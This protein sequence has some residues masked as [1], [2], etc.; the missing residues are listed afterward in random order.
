M[1]PSAE[2]F[3]LDSNRRRLFSVFQG[4]EQPPR[5][6][7]LFCHPLGEEKKCAHRAFHETAR[8]LARRGVASL[9]FDFSGCGDSDGV[10][11]DFAIEDWLADIQSAWNELGRRAPHGEH[12]LLGLRLGAALVVLACQ[13]LDDVAGLALWQPMIEGK[14]EFSAE[15]RRLLIQDMMTTG[16]ARTGRD[17]I[18]AALERGDGEVELDGYPI[19][20]QLYRDICRVDLIVR[21]PALPEKCRIVQFARVQRRIESFAEVTGI[22]SVVID[23]PPIWTRSDFLPTED[24]GDLLAR[25]G[26]L[27]LLEPS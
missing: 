5:A 23:V 8:A 18:L 12:F 6:T 2:S 10:F 22:P 15:L 27:A 25:D 7:V 4:T 21:R 20:S 16:K 24:T 9:R 26:V 19:T 13:H 17:E 3:F 1:V 14:P 11:S